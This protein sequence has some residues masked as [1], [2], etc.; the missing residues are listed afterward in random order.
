VYPPN[1][2][3]EN[4]LGQAGA[5]VANLV[6]KTLGYPAWVLLIGTLFFLVVP[7]F[8]VKVTFPILRAVGLAMLV[9]GLCGVNAVAFPAFSP[10][11]GLAGGLLGDVIGHEMVARF[12]VL[13][14]M[15]W[16]IAL[17]VVGAVVAMDRYL[18]AAPEGDS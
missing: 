10:M 13:G 12:N 2:V 9:A 7:V 15:I 6:F 18:I 11:P 8:R 14:S 5:G 1:P 16:L 3:A 4:P 17:V